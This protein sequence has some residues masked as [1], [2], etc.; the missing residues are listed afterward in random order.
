MIKPWEKKRVYLSYVYYYKLL[1][2]LKDEEK[3]YFYALCTVCSSNCLH[4]T[5]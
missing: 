2:Q 1:T 5:K 3:N 4:C